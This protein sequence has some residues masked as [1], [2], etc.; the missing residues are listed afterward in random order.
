MKNVSKLLSILLCL[1]M[2]IGLFTMA[3][4]A[5]EPPVYTADF[6]TIG[7]KTSYGTYDSTD[8]WNVANAQVQT[9]DDSTYANIEAGK[10]AAIINGKTTTVGS[11]T[12]PSLAGGVASISFKY[13]NFFNE[14]NGV[15]V[16]ITISGG[17][18]DVTK[19]LTV[20]NSSVTKGN[21]YEY[22]WNLST[23]EMAKV[24]KNACTVT[25]TNLSP[26]NSN[27]NKDRV[28]IWNLTVTAAEAVAAT[29]VT[30]VTVNET[31]SVQAGLSTTLTATVAPDNATNKKVTW[32]S[33]DE[34]VATVSGG[35]VTGVKAGTATITVT[36]ED[37]S[38]TDTC[39]VTVTAAPTIAATPTAGNA[40]KF[41]LAQKTL[42]KYLWFSGEMDGNFLGTTENF[43]EAVDVIPVAVEGGWHISF[44]KDNE[45]KYIEIYEYQAGSLAVHIADTPSTVHTWDATAKTFFA[46]LAD[47]TRFFGT[48][49]SFDTISS[50][51]TF[52]ITGSNASA[53]D[54]SQFIAHLYTTPVTGVT[55][56]K[57][58]QALV[59]GGTVELVATVAPDSA[60]NKAVTWTSSDSTVAEVSAAGKVTAKK[61][62][63]AT[64]TVTTEDGGKSATC[65]ITVSAAAVPATSVTLDKT[66]ASLAV[67]ADVTLA[68]T[69]APAGSTDTVAW[70]TSNAAVATVA[71]GKIT[72]V[73]PGTATITATAG[74]KSA[75]CTVTVT[76]AVS[77]VELNKE[78][79]SVVVESELDLSATVTANPDAADYKKVTWTTSDATIATV[80]NGKV[81][82]LKTGT[83]TITATSVTDTTKKATC[84]VTVVSKPAANAGGLITSIEQ[85][86]TGT[87][88]LVAGNGFA[89]AT[90]DGTWLTAAEPTVSGTQIA[91]TKNATWTLTV[92]DG[93]VS[94]KDSTGKYIAPKGG[95]NNG[96]KEGEYWWTVEC[97]DGKFSFLGN[98]E[99]T[100]RL[101]CNTESENKFRAYKNTTATGDYAEKY[102]STFS[103]YAVGDTASSTGDAFEPMV[104]VLALAAVSALAVL[105]L[106]KKKFSF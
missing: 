86:K 7:K 2:V 87:Y 1:A 92:K 106:N 102:P 68:A 74:S 28:A 31:A 63:T 71:N 90:L 15:S 19:T 55:L 3:V 101:A 22:T 70:T 57:T 84:T 32:S 81:K 14:S 37:G 99:D 53:A 89:P 65:A 43:A 42:N 39:A 24:N 26:S 18:Q 64:I 94:I 79:A 44:V 61:A 58:S 96:I 76:A 75:T 17:T 20:A 54:V 30:G 78:T 23:D 72:A 50:S 4:S 60:T 48:Y 103:V 51:D 88:V 97:V 13:A 33:S 82:A 95:N 38:F 62:G 52:R 45:T 93:K 91:D 100:V 36:T 8:G 40:Y 73:A 5:A 6:A 104:I 12:S 10:Y 21:A 34:T 35:K 77:K 27:S 59:V 9:H 41:G 16:Q 66:T 49:N 69:V 25:I 29:G 67:G 85:L 80:E 98:G 47:K 11:I 105:A 56:D 46:A 83:V